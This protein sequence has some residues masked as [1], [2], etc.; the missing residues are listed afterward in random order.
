[1]GSSACC[2]DE[3]ELDVD[4]YTVDRRFPE[5]FDSIFDMWAEAAEELQRAH[6]AQAGVVDWPQHASSAS[7]QS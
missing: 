2:A 4:E 1:M 3:D 7:G 6:T 5:P